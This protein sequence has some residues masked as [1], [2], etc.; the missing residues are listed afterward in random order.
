MRI[1]RPVA[2]R[3]GINITLHLE[4]FDRAQTTQWGTHRLACLI[5]FGLPA[6]QLIQLVTLGQVILP[7]GLF[8]AAQ[9]KSILSFSIHVHS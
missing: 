9:P 2:F 8:E 6:S 5:V 1:I 4:Y 7:P 3:L